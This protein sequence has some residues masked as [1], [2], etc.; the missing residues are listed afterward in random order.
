MFNVARNPDLSENAYEGSTWFLFIN[1]ENVDEVY[2]QVVQSDHKPDAP[3]K[4]EF[5]GGRTFGIR[6]LNGLTLVFYQ[7][8]ENQ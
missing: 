8:Y 3:P 7:L 2:R 4:D 6:D 5:W 1:V